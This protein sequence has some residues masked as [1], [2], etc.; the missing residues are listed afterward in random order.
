MYRELLKNQTLKSRPILSVHPKALSQKS[1]QGFNAP[2]L[3]QAHTIPVVKTVESNLECCST[4]IAWRVK[5]DVS[6]KGH[7]M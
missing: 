1:L 7:L 5:E 2:L 4:G 6:K 3:K